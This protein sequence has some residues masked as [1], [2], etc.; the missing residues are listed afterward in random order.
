MPAQDAEVPEDRAQRIADLVRE[1]GSFLD[2]AVYDP[3]ADR[4]TAIE[5]YGIAL[6]PELPDERFEAV[7][8]A[9]KHRVIQ[10]LGR[11]RIGALLAP[12]GLIY[13]ITGV[14]TP[15]ESDARI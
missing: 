3:I 5:E 15:G 10:E 8:L 7:I 4:E 11:E 9:V 12:G 6:L 13:D 1:L 2:V 14:L